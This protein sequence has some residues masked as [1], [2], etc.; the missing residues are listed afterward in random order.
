MQEHAQKALEE[1]KAIDQV[2]GEVLEITEQLRQHEANLAAVEM[3]LKFYKDKM[4]WTERRVKEAMTRWKNCGMPAR[5]I[6][7]SRPRSRSS[8]A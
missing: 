7:R 6:R 5:S 3:R 8:P 4:G 1:V 2:R